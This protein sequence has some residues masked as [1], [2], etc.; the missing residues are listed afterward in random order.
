[1]TVVLVALALWLLSR[2]LAR[3][4]R[5]TAWIGIGVVS[6]LACLTR[7]N[8]VLFLPVLALWTLAWKP[9]SGERSK[10][11]RSG[12]AL[13][14]L[15]GAALVIAPATLHNRLAG[16]EWILTTSN[17]GQNF[18]IGNNPLN[19]SGEYE[20]LPFVDP[21]PQHEEAGFAAEALRRGGRAM[22]AGEV[23][24]FW[25]A[26]AR[27]WIRDEPSAWAALLWR[28]LRNYWGAYEIPDNLDYYL[29]RETAP[30]LR[31]PVP[32][33]GLVGPLGL[34]GAAL[35]WKRRGW[36]RL[37]ILFIGVYSLSVILFFVF[38]RFRMAMMPALFVL[39]GFALVE[40]WNRGRDA[41]REPAGRPALLR[42]AAALLAFLALLNLPV[43]ARED[44]L[45]YRL[46]RAVGLPTRV[47]TSAT[48]HFNLGVTL[49]AIAAESE[50]PGEILRRA[51]TELRE[52]VAREPGHA[53][54]RVELGK[55]LARQGR[56][57]EA[58]EVYREAAAIQPGDYRIQHTLGLL[59]QREGETAAA[60]LSFRR[61][62]ELA[63]GH[64]PSATRLG[65]TLLEQGR[66]LEA[67]SAFRLALRLAPGDRAAADGLR[68][69]GAAAASGP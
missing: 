22:T 62:L 47:E 33:F 61:A 51:E 31:L 29:Y 11:E 26:E 57:R 45:A 35:A 55:V 60:E 28:K 23:S 46:A 7:G 54:L 4:G 8:L 36:P 13:L 16:R 48:G 17:A 15:L 38:S 2:T 20:R 12:P 24:R 41:L 59:H 3:G 1:M 30:L 6:G 14:L 27:A 69:A 68:A 58:I 53:M 66:A 67:A 42:A 34:L 65:Q 63:P 56:N 5:D 44:S 39:A 10:V 9:A 25:F 21:N 19:R 43:R 32:G 18:Y 49:A 52:A 50:D 40:L 64:A 37:L